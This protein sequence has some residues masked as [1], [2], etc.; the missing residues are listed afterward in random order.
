MKMTD[1]INSLCILFLTLSACFAIL[2]LTDVATHVLLNP[3]FSCT[4]VP[5]NED[6][7]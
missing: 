5:I 7:P 2:R 1:R 4:P 6:L 3:D